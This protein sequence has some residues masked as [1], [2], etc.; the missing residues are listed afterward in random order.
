[1]NHL[2]VIIVAVS[3]SGGSSYFVYGKYITLSIFNDND[4][5]R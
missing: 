1:M 5:V 3:L 4:M 2:S